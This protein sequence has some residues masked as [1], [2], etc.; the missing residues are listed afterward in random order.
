ME[1]GEK[2]PSNPLA[3]WPGMARSSAANEADARGGVSK[4]SWMEDGLWWSEATVRLGANT[5]PG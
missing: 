5:T 4:H 3:P 1:A 2:P